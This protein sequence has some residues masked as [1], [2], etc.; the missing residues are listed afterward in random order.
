M[1]THDDFRAPYIGASHTS[2]ERA[3]REDAE[4]TTRRRWVDLLDLLF[5]AGLSGHTWSELA[6]ITGLHHGQVSGA[7]SKLHENEEI[8]QL[9]RKRNRSHVY[10]HA[11]F[12]DQLTEPF[13]N[14]PVQTR[15]N[16]KLA[17]LEEVFEAAH[18]LCF[19]QSQNM[20]AKWDALRAALKKAEG[21]K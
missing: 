15:A 21:L 9:H 2:K 18:G 16:A 4:G 11:D 13:N 1:S 14:Q 6:D 10:I 19:S 20:A 7:L 12:V 5:K 8:V 17:A 3:L